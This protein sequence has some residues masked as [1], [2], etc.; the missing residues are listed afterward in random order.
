MLSTGTVLQNRYRIVS[1]LKKGGMGAIYRAWHLSLNMPIA[2]KEMVPKPGLDAKNLN[3]LRQQFQQEAAVLAHLNHPNLVRVIDHFEEASKV[4]L[5]MDFVEGESLGD[6]I[7]QEGAL[8]ED[9]VLEWADQ[10]LDALAYCHDEGVIHRDIK[11]Q[12]VLIRSDKRAMLVD[13]GLVK[14]WDPNDPQ[15]R[16]AMRGLGTPEYAPPEQYGTLPGHTSSRSDIYSLGATLYHALTGQAPMT[17]GDRTTALVPFP[18]VHDL[19]PQVSKKT[20]A[21]ISRAMELQVPKRFGNAKEM[22][23]ALRNDS[24]ALDDL[25][26]VIGTSGTTQVL[27]GIF[28]VAA[29]A[30]FV[31]VT[32]WIAGGSGIVCQPSRRPTSTATP[33][34]IPQPIKLPTLPLV[35]TS[36]AQPTALPTSTATPT[37]I[38]QPIKL[39]TL[40][41]VPT[42][43]AQPTALP[44]ST[45]TPTTTPQPTLTTPPTLAPLPTPTAAPTL[46][47]PTAIPTDAS[48]ATPVSIVSPVVL[49][50]HH[51]RYITAMG[52]DEGWT[53]KQEPGLDDC[54][55]FA[56][57]RWYGD[58]VSLVT[59][60][61]RYVTA[62]T[63]GATDRDWALT[64]ELEASD[65]AQFTLH[66]RDGGEVVF[67]TCADRFFT[68]LDGSRDAEVQWVLIARTDRI[69]DWEEFSVQ[70]P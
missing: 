58:T 34:P 38:P 67:E 54:G 7:E 42:S 2:I 66:Q 60:Y 32:L 17:A 1:L 10:L 3:Q 19:N 14:L 61:G 31:L 9:E 6:L 5:V 49:V 46:A 29:L 39:P 56:L 25:A 4:Y 55:K 15:T 37:P 63:S 23:A 22:Q 24:H 27:S 65:C 21:A 11:P 26:R 16:T 53:L 50:T 59:C 44:T 62:P 18:S 41:L 68:A 30:V 51:G 43:T 12:N 33:T 47:V 48:T 45:A 36:T 35:P 70:G 13:F 8:P 69:G 57:I 64:Q 20:S 52:A 40:T 28:G